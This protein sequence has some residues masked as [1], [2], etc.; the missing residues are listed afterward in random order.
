MFQDQWIV[1]VKRE[2]WVPNRNTW[3]CSEH[4]VTGQKSNDALAPNYTV[5]MKSNHNSQGVPRVGR[6]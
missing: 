1:A 3:I 2:N 5:K 4:F 6:I